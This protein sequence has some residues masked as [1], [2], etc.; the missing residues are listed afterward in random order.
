MSEYTTVRGSRVIRVNKVGGGTLGHR[1]AGDWEVTVTDSGTVV[2]DDVITTGTPKFY[3][4]V[5]DLAEEFS[6]D[7]D[8]V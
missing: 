3:C 5:A 6:D 7:L 2:L 4:E 8:E 1:Y